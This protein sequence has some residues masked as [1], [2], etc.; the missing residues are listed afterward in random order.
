MSEP[1]PMPDAGRDDR[2]SRVRAALPAVREAAYLNTG[3]C[4]PLPATAW[5]AMRAALEADMAPGRIVDGRF[6]AVAERIEEVRRRTAALMGASRDEIALTTCTSHGL[7][8]A[9][10]GL[11]WAPGDEVLTTRHEHPGLQV[12]LAA[13]SRRMGVR[14]RYLDFDTY[15]PEAIVDAF[16]RAASSR[17]RLLAFSHVL[18]TNGAVMPVAELAELA[19]GLGA[20][21]LVDGAQSA[22]AIPVDAKALGVDFY[23]VPGQKWLCGPEGTGA[24]YVAQ[25]ALPDVDP[26]FCGYM[27]ASSVQADAPAFVPRPGA[28]RFE[29]GM[30]L[31]AAVA[32]LAASLSWLEGLGWTWCRERIA[33]LALRLRRHLLEAGAQ[34]LTPGAAMNGPVSGLVSFRVPGR[35]PTEVAA[36]L[37]RQG[38][39]VRTIP[40]PHD[41]V[42]ASTGFFN[43]EDEIDGLAEAVGGLLR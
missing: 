36:A 41:A 3:T 27:A 5:E 12:P 34:V 37:R 42:R 14:V 30:P 43:T 28:A 26:T 35:A 9:L 17:T 1:L 38:Y 33:S 7:N 15:D 25:S 31:P 23:A 10:W 29:V 13:L 8:I 11:R 21:T 19:R 6:D 2:L 18:W 4:G 32:G 16:R 22:G 24:L 39:L 40:E 20:R